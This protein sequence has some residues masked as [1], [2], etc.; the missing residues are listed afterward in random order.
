MCSISNFFDFNY[1]ISDP[2]IP[3]KY[4]TYI[5]TASAILPLSKSA[6]A[7]D[8]GPNLFPTSESMTGYDPLYV[9]D[10]GDYYIEDWD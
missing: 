5:A 8:V 7:K 9:Q 10:T 2:T 3:T 4:Q 6:G 1:L